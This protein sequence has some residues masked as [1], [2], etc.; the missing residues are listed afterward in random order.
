MIYPEAKFLSSCESMKSNML[1]ASK[2]Q[3]CDRLNY[4]HFHSKREKYERRGK[5]S[6]TRSKFNTVSAITFFLLFLQSQLAVFLLL[7][8][9]YLYF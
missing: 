6:Q 7:V 8:S 4:R 3:Q 5:G 9:S 2:I 1:F